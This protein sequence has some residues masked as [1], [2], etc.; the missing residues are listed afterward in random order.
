[1]L[2][3]GD[4]EAALADFGLSKYTRGADG[5][6]WLGFT[7][8]MA[9]EL[10]QAQPLISSKADVWSAGVLLYEMSTGSTQGV[11]GKDVAEA[12]RQ[13]RRWEVPQLPP[14]IDAFAARMIRLLLTVD[15]NARPDCSTLLTLIQA[16][17]VF[18]PVPPPAAVNREEAI[19]SVR[20]TA[21]AGGAAAGVVAAAA[22]GPAA[23]AAVGAF[24]VTAAVTAPATLAG[25]AV[26]AVTRYVTGSTD[27]SVKTGAGCTTGLVTGAAFGAVLGPPGIVL[28]AIGGAVGGALAGVALWRWRR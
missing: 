28:G 26:F 2:L 5:G 22:V 8:Y 1:M 20:Y 14:D 7:P 16:D 11:R 21:A 3:S 18:A 24:A 12:M 9:P 6:A 23:V 25:S 10:F 27:A 17:P 4:C 13:G 15:T 19:A